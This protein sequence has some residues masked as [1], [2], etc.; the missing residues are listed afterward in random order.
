MLFS[1]IQGKSLP[2][3]LRQGPL[4]CL[5][6]GRS[7][8]ILSKKSLAPCKILTEKRGLVSLP[9]LK[10]CL[11]VWVSV[12]LKG[13][14]KKIKSR[15]VDLLWF[16]VFIVRLFLKWV[17][18]FLLTCACSQGYLLEKKSSFN[19]VFA[20][21]HRDQSRAVAV[22]LKCRFKGIVVSEQQLWMKSM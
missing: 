18:L 16:S 9:S 1:F 15:E 22:S 7:P 19:S 8:E 21:S 14:G 13:K 12:L 2:L 6:T 11:G 17:T 3:L 10:L 20:P 4:V 5:A